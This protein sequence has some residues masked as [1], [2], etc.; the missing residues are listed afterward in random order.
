MVPMLIRMDTPMIR[1]NRRGSIQALVAKNNMAKNTG[2]TKAIIVAISE[3]AVLRKFSAST[4]GPRTKMSAPFRRR[5]AS[6]A[7][8][9]AGE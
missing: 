3:V 1:Q 9:V 6:T 4:A 5:K 2:K 7:L 8:P